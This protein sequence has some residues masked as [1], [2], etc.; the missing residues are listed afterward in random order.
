MGA[1]LGMPEGC[2]MWKKEMART[3]GNDRQGAACGK[4]IYI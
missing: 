1:W 2:Y 4:C 3:A